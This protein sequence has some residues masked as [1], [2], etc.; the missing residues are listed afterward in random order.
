[1]YT[2][3]NLLDFLSLAGSRGLMPAATASALSVAV[4]NVLGVL[5]DNERNNLHQMD[6][7]AVLK[8]F[9]NKRARE[10]NPSSLKEY[11]RRLRRAIELYERWSDD[12]ANFSIKTRT[13]RSTGKKA[14]ADGATARPADSADPAVRSTTPQPEGDTYSSAF[15]IRTDRVVV[16]TNIPADLTGPEAERLANFVRMLPVE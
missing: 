16:L 1:M 10:F 9:T 2:M 14:R 13:S 8:R 11:S 5:D 6:I 7:D 3:D 15:P 4:R 12:P